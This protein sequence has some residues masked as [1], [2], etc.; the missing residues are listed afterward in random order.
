[1]NANLSRRTVEYAVN[2]AKAAR[3]DIVLLSLVPTKPVHPAAHDICTVGVQMNAMPIC[4]RAR[5]S[6]MALETARRAGVHCDTAY[7][8]SSSLTDAVIEFS[9][10]Y[11]CDVIYLEEDKNSSLVEPSISSAAITEVVKRTSISVLV[12]R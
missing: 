12:F 6:E 7:S 4:D 3:G 1:M 9:K 10:R 2:Y 11:C 8:N 5:I